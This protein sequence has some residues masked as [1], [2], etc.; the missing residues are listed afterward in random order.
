MGTIKIGKAIYPDDWK[1]LC[2]NMELLSVFRVYAKNH[3]IW[4]THQFLTL[5]FD[6]KRDYGL[7][8]AKGARF[9]INLAFA[10][11]KAMDELAIRGDWAMIAWNSHIRK[12]REEIID[13]IQRDHLNGKANRFW[14]SDEFAVFFR[15]EVV[16]R[17]DKVAMVLGISNKNKHILYDLMV[18]ASRKDSITLRNRIELLTRCEELC[19]SKKE[20]LKTL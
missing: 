8:I 7:Y 16:K 17:A 9:W 20:I 2:R 4:D 15:S 18:A 14:K 10:T 3:G 13:M 12:A 5:E 19:P 1:G 11:R 6:P